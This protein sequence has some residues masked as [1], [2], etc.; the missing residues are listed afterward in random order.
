M[1][2]LKTNTK[3]TANAS[4]G[5]GKSG[6]KRAGPKKPAVSM[7]GET[8]ARLKKEAA[9]RGCSIT[10]LLETILERALADRP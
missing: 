10:E 6:E 4:S 7:R 2:S 1:S 9:K 3:A 5:N 8:Y